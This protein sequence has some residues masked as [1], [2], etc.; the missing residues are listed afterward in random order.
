[1]TCE[2]TAPCPLSGILRT[3]RGECVAGHN[4]VH[5]AWTVVVGYLFTEVPGRDGRSRDAGGY[6]RAGAAG[7]WVHA[8]DCLR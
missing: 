6:A 8:P 5:G 4:G 3:L 2:A 1:M 7:A